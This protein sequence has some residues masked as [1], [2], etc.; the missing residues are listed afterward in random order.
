MRDPEA[1]G[2][3]L[4]I[5]GDQLL[6]GVL[7][8]ADE[9]LGRLLADHLAA[10][11]RVVA[12]LGERLLVLDDVLGRLRHDEARRVEARPSG[13]ARDL[14]ELAGA[15]RPHPGAVVLR[16]SREQHGADGHVDAD[17]EGVGAAD[18]LQQTGLRQL[19]H[20]APVL[21]QHAGVVHADPVPHVAGE[22]AAELGGEAEVADQVGDLVL[23]LARAHVDAHQRLRPLH[24]LRLREVHDVDREPAWSSSSSVSVSVS[25]VSPYS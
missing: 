19:L 22:I 5:G 24:G 11:L 13:A 17:A 14:V 15:Q 18:D 7:R 20:Q 12:R 4:R 8:P 1:G 2:Q 10:L 6:E 25:G 9:A 16:Q 23:L 3:R 21:G